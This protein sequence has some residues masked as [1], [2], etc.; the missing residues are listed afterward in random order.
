VTITFASG[1]SGHRCSA[2]DNIFDNGY[3][4]TNDSSSLLVMDTFAGYKDG[5]FTPTIEG[6]TG[7]GTGTYTKQQGWYTRIG[8]LV[9][10]AVDIG[11]S[12]HDGTGNI[13]LA[14]LPYA[15]L[16][17]G[18]TSPFAFFVRPTS[19]TFSN[20]LGLRFQN[21]GSKANLFTYAT[22]ASPA[23][24]ALDTSAAFQVCG[25]YMMT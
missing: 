23:D 14:G 18:D 9:F 17:S 22:A 25:C 10:I 20:D 1:T 6:S 2:T 7:A 15:S 4:M 16:S 8:K 13:V 5:T 11:W 3:T 24:V 12:A 19:L 21:G